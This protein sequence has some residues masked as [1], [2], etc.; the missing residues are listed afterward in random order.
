MHAAY[1]NK[2]DFSIFFFFKENSKN[3]N[4]ISFYIKP[5]NNL[6]QFDL[7]NL[8]YYTYNGLWWAINVYIVFQIFDRKK[9]YWLHL[10]CDQTE[11]F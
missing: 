6:I 11:K 3:F 7:S 10:F 9:C 2:I 1:L 8:S 5:K 4:F